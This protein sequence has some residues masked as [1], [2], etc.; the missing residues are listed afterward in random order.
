VRAL[1]EPARTD[2]AARK[3]LVLLPP[4]Y[5][6]PEDFIEQGFVSAV[7]ERARPVDLVLVELALQPFLERR[8]LD[9]LRQEIVL[10]ARALGCSVYFAG[11]SLGALVALFYAE[12]YPGEV[13]GLCLIA[14]YLGSHLVT[15]EIERAGGLARWQPGEL[16]EEDEER[17]AWRFI[18][19][20]ATGALR[21]PHPT[22]HLGFGTEDRFSVAHRLMAAVL[23]PETM[24]TMPGGHDWR[25]WRQLWENF[26]D[27]R[28]TL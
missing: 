2:L 3:R 7:R 24:N 19:A 8:V 26:L 4:A 21:R 27:V 15:G 25:T 18:Q 22:L 23:T 13:E 14:P 9:L 1:Y 5:A 12:R 6:R 17:R 20:L 11:I 10:P 28:S 16:E